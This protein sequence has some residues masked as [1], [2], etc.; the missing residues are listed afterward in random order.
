MH[1]V[2]VHKQVQERQ[3][4]LQ[5]KLQDIHTPIRNPDKGDRGRTRALLPDDTPSLEPLTAGDVH[6]LL[7]LGKLNTS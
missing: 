4:W 2:G 5:M 7:T 3:D 6:Y 1:N